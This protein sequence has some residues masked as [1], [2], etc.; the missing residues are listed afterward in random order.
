MAA[1]ADR[2]PDDTVFYSLFPDSGDAAATADLADLRLRIL[3]SI[4]PFV[5]NYIWQHQPF[6]LCPAG[7]GDGG[8]RDRPLPPHLRGKTKFGDNL[9]D[10]WFVVFLLFHIS[11][12][13]PSLSVQVADNDGQFLLIEAAYSLPRWLNPDTAANRVFIRAGHLHILPKSRFPS[14]PPLLQALSV[15]AGR[16][17]E[18]DTRAPEKVQAAIRRRIVEYPERAARNVHRAVVRVPAAVAQ[19]LRHEPCLI[20]AAVEGFYDR[21]VDAMKFAARMERFLENGRSEELVRVP[22]RMSRAMYAQLVQQ[23]FQAPKCY[24]MPGRGDGGV[25][26]YLEAELGMKIA[27][28]FEMMYQMRMKLGSD[29]RG[30]AWDA[31]MESFESSGYF[32]DLLPGSKE[33]NMLLEKVQEYFRQSNVLCRA[34]YISFLLDLSLPLS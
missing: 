2:L 25:A 6:H 20:S 15:L 10:E 1:V 21:D 34:R 17:A 14:N 22:V 31:F 30:S 33:Y 19:V 12:A 3:D 28:G 13:F 24:P 27:C 23:S 4:A 16:E 11:N 8:S 7:G 26:E 18:A 9:E 32:R 5:S 29:G